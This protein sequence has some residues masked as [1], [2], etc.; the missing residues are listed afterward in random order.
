MSVLPDFTFPGGSGS[1]AAKKNHVKFS[2]DFP[3][4]VPEK[5][6]EMQA[7]ERIPLEFD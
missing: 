2:N 1:R 3:L 7:G 6:M 5:I 4:E